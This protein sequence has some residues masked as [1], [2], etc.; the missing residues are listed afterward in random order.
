MINKHPDKI[1]YWKSDGIDYMGQP[2]WSGPYTVDCRWEDEQRLYISDTGKEEK[3]RSVI[4]LKAEILDIGDYVYN[5]VSSDL[6][7][8]TGS[9]EVKQPR[10]IKNLRGTRVEYR[11]IV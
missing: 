2:N 10:R 7:P 1:T 8:P 11:V 5:G 4:Y 9:F 3:G 6:T